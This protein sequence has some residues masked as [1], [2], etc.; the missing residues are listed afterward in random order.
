MDIIEVPVA[1]RD[2]RSRV[3]ARGWRDAM[4]AWGEDD[5]GGGITSIVGRQRTGHHDALREPAVSAV[6]EVACAGGVEGGVQR[7]ET[8]SAGIDGPVK[9][10]DSISSRCSS[11]SPE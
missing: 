11:G 2:W 3:R 8:D 1:K 4:T 5:V 9:R 6:P 7:K 10:V